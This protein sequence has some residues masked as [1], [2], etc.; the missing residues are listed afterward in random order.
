[1]L[2]LADVTSCRPSSLPF[3]GQLYAPL[4]AEQLSMEVEEVHHRMHEPVDRGDLLDYVNWYGTPLPRR[5]IETTARRVSPHAL[6]L[7]N[8]HR[9]VWMVKGLPY[10]PETFEELTSR[11]PKCDAKLR[12]ETARAIS[13]C[14]T[15][16]TPLQDHPGRR[17]SPDLHGD[18]K[19]V[20][21]LV[22]TDARIREDAARSLPPPFS[23][24][25]PGDVFHAAVELGLIASSPVIF[26]TTRRKNSLKDIGSSRLG[27]NR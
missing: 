17:V 27:R 9:A 8:C 10:C 12:W 1:V 19:S 21:D 13:H 26:R 22:S 6:A 5:L 16:E 7:S 11:C 2:E 14:E 4:L 20:A 18:A 3:T 23:S 15:C 25:T 24:W